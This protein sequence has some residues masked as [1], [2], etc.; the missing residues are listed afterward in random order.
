MFWIITGLSCIAGVIFG[1]MGAYAWVYTFGWWNFILCVLGSM[2]LG[3]LVSW[4]VHKEK[5]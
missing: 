4:Q 2:I 3:G 5:A 1:I